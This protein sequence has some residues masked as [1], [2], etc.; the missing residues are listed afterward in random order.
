MTNELRGAGAQRVVR[1]NRRGLR[2]RGAPAT[3]RQQL[4]IEAADRRSIRPLPVIEAIAAGRQLELRLQDTARIESGI[5][6]L[7]LPEAADQQARA[8]E[9]HDRES[10]LGNHRGP[11]GSG[12]RRGRRLRRASLRR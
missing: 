12:V 3:L 2:R 10:D 6:L 7:Q 8:G 9:E 4:L 5:D 11:I 1:G